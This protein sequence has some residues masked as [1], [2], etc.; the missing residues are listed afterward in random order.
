MC[1]SNSIVEFICG[2]DVD[3][4]EGRPLQWNTWTVIHASYEPRYNS[5]SEMLVE[6]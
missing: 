4:V 6:T 1:H 5:F 3:N 2:N